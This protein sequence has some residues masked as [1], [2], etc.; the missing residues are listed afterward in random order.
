MG[1]KKAQGSSFVRGMSLQA[2][3][4]KWNITQEVH[5]EEDILKCCMQ[6]EGSQGILLKIFFLKS[7]QLWDETVNCPSLF[8]QQ[9]PIFRISSPHIKI[10]CFTCFLLDDPTSTYVVLPLTCCTGALVSLKWMRTLH[11]SLMLQY[12]PNMASVKENWISVTIPQP[13]SL[14]GAD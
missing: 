8:C 4:R 11:L 6:K 12:C 10:K 7:G 13:W 1:L 3:V 5:L 14:W 2:V 9:C